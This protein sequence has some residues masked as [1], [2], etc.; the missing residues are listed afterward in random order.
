M[1]GQDPMRPEDIS[2]GRRCVL[3]GI[4]GLRQR[5]LDD[6]SGN[7]VALSQVMGKVG[8]VSVAMEIL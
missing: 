5:L 1:A 3:L 4:E 2:G 8:D 7:A 6:R